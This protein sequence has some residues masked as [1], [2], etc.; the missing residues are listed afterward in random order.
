[1]IIRCPDCTTGFKLPD[2]RVSEDPIK[3]RCSK[4]SHVFQV[5]LV[6]G[7]PVLYDDE[8]NRLPDEDQQ[9]EVESD[10]GAQETQH[11]EQESPNAATGE[12]QIGTAVAQT[13]GEEK[14]ETTSDTH[15]GTP[16][17]SH[18]GS[19]NPQ[20]ATDPG[21]DE[22][23]RGTPAGAT[24]DAAQP[25]QNAGKE[26]MI[27]TPGATVERQAPVQ[28]QAGAASPSQEEADQDVASTSVNE[29][30]PV[31]QTHRGSPTAGT[32]PAPQNDENDTEAQVTAESRDESPSPQRKSS[33]SASSDYDPF[34]HTD[35]DIGPKTSRA[36]KG[37]NDDRAASPDDG[38][39][40]KAVSPEPPA[41]TQEAVELPGAEE[42]QQQVEAARQEQEGQDALRETSELTKEQAGVDSSTT[43]AP[44]EA[45][46]GGAQTDGARA[47]ADAGGAQGEPANTQAQAQNQQ[48]SGTRAQP[49]DGGGE[50]FDSVEVGEDLPQDDDSHWQQQQSAQGGEAPED[51]HQEYFDP[52]TGQKQVQGQPAG[53]EQQ[54]SSTSPQPSPT[55]SPSPAAQQKA[56]AGS[57]SQASQP[58]SDVS[59]SPEPRV[60][61]DPS[62]V[63]SNSWAIDEVDRVDA[64][65]FGSS[66]LQ[67][68]AN[69]LLI[70]LIVG[71]G[72]L[73]VV[74]AQNDWFV[75][76][77]KFRQML[78][79]AFQDGE[80][81][82]REKW[83]QPAEPATP[84]KPEKP[85]EFKNV[86][87][88][89]L[90]VGAAE[91]DSEEASKVL[92]LKGDA[93][94]VSQQKYL[95]VEV[96]GIIYDKHG[97][98]ADQMT[99]KLGANI[100]PKE[101][102][103]L[104]SPKKLNTLLP[105]DSSP[106]ETDRSQPFTIIFPKVPKSVAKGKK[107]KYHVEIAKKV[108]A[109]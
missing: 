26:T 51:Y 82:P 102:N 21:T 32:E 41:E 24:G 67:K 98:V 42:I 37:E 33:K 8:G 101:V 66:G 23:H 69:F 100:A 30:M 106:L 38:Q 25:Q 17:P 72:F 54:A 88:Q 46:T 62:P 35:T 18:E 109:K 93:K 73:A 13:S 53:Q 28:D 20:G 47:A 59:A 1:M 22:T 99:A 50:D 96:R 58:T 79:V 43:D 91:G 6:S 11:E 48:A 61:S 84:P 77:K 29:Q 95:G 45:E 105:K 52:E 86:F 34:P 108:S 107:V 90:E 49:A 78:Q 56:A 87:I 92:V 4:C 80:Y 9:A 39:T 12:T 36:I 14:E 16:A 27:G 75:D 44:A 81:E 10:E 68:F 5:G 64:Q 55:T 70:L 94:N 3:V 31:G 63:Q 97:K 103:A 83:T 40:Q 65:Q 76:F 57:A 19:A 89:V 7:D 60:D 2:E 104:D 74:A 15:L 71:S 85:I